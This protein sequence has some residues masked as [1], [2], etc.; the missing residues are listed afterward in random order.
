MAK[1]PETIL[2][3]KI[4]N[5]L[6]LRDWLTK[7]THGNMFQSGFPDVFAAHVRHGYRWIEV[8]R[9]KYKFTKAQ[10]DNFKRF[11]LHGV[12]VWILQAPTEE[13]YMKLF[14]APNWE[15]F[16]Y[17]ELLRIKAVR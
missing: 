5:F 13:E 16:Y 14:R 8:K 2:Q 15:E 17:A 6:K 11:S 3:D 9:E 1:K 10:I 4:C 7:E 12:G